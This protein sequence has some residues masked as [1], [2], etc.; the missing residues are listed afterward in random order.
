MEKFLN[1]LDSNLSPNQLIFDC[2]ACVHTHPIRVGFT[3]GFEGAHGHLF[4]RT[5]ESIDDLTV[6]P[7]IRPVEAYAGC[8][9][10]GRITGGMVIW[11]P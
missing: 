1:E 8:H 4:T 10:L 7:S 2:P 9:F 5:G 3:P 6:Y 11:G